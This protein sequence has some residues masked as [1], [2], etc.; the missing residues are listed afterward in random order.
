MNTIPKKKKQPKSL[1][2]SFVFAFNKMTNLCAR[3]ERKDL[4]NNIK[5]PAHI[6]ARLFDLA[7]AILKKRDIFLNSINYRFSVRVC[8]L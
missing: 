7:E 5:K 4:K 3:K 1:R 2:K 8:V 6:R